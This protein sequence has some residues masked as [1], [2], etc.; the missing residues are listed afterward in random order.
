MSSLA[1]RT[2]SAKG[3][4]S[5]GRPAKSSSRAAQA[6]KKTSTLHQSFSAPD[7]QASALIE[8]LAAKKNPEPT[9]ADRARA[10]ECVGELDP[11]LARTRELAVAS[12]AHGK[13]LAGALEPFLLACLE[14]DIG[15]ASRLGSNTGEN[16][17]SALIESVSE[18]GIASGLQDLSTRQI[19][20][21]VIVI[22]VV[23]GSHGVAQGSAAKALAE[24]LLAPE[25]RRNAPLGA[26]NAAL[27]GAGIVGTSELAAWLASGAAWQREMDHLESKIAIGEAELEALSTD[28]ANTRAELEDIRQVSEGLEVK[29]KAA[30]AEAEQLRVDVNN[31]RMVSRGTQHA[32]QHEGSQLRNSLAGFLSDELLPLSESVKEGLGLD[33]PRVAH[34]L[35]RL[36]DLE[37]AIGEK[38]K[39]LMF[40]D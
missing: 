17:I 24:I 38:V 12:A 3:K 16:A 36:E 35:E 27:I 39:W 4:S 21:L 26:G 29:L 34:S 32:K 19:S 22:M 8:S 40:S 15:I 28:A 33:P 25:E 31:Q 20:A 2:K 23:C 13:R 7:A 37:H 14:Q 11:D 9:K 5:G 30:R 10:L 18:M 1:G 6:V